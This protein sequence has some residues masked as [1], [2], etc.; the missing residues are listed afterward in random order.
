MRLVVTINWST[1]APRWSLCAQKGPSSI[2]Q[3]LIDSHVKYSTSVSSYLR[4]DV[5]RDCLSILPHLF[6][7]QYRCIPCH[8]LERFF[9][10]ITRCGSLNISKSHGF[11]PV[12]ARQLFQKTGFT[13]CQAKLC[14]RVARTNCS[15]QDSINWT[16]QAGV[17][18]TFATSDGESPNVLRHQPLFS[19]ARGYAKL[20]ARSQPSIRPE[21]AGIF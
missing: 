6:V 8:R 21:E 18:N 11:G 1:K 10:Y 12:G 16:S 2:S 9:C 13:I 19:L 15:I 5:V 3:P 14:H 7:R 20:A 4:F 17:V